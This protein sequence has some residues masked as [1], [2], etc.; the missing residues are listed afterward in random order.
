MENELGDRGEADEGLIHL[1]IS[2]STDGD[3]LRRTCPA[4]GLDFKTATSPDQF[5]NILTPAIQRTGMEYGIDMGV[6]EVGDSGTLT[7]PYCGS[8]CSR[9]D[10]HTDGTMEYCRRIAFREIVLPRIRQ[11]FSGLR[12]FD[13]GLM[14]LTVTHSAGTLPPRP[15]HGPEPSD[16]A[17]VVFLCCM[18]R[19]KLLPGWLGEA[20]CPSCGTLTLTV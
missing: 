8:R 6:E 20:Y 19:A 11:A 15:I 18:E 2:I 4:C 5:S 1:S 3:F 16:L 12:D 13:A 10:A 14:S 9:Q 7:C 17:E